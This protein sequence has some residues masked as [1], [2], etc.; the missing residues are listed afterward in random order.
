MG[1]RTRRRY[2]SQKKLLALIMLG[3]LFCGV[4]GIYFIIKDDLHPR[5]SRA[6]SRVDLPGDTIDEQSIWMTKIESQNRLLENKLSFLEETVKS[7]KKKEGQQEKENTLLKMELKNLK[8][9]LSD[10]ATN[11]LAYQTAKEPPRSTNTLSFDDLD[12]ED[13]FTPSEPLMSLVEYTYEGDLEKE[14]TTFHVDEMIP[15]GTTVKALIVSSV[16]APCGALSSSDPQPI[17]LRLLD[18]ARLP[19]SVRVRLKGGMLIGGAYGDI[20]SER[21]YIRLERLT[22]VKRDGNFIE[23]DVAGFVSGEDGKYGVRGV[24]VDKSAALI[25]NAAFSGFFG[26]MA[27]YFQSTL[28]AQNISPDEQPPFYYLP[29][30]I[31]YDLLQNSS[32]QGASNAL[33]KISEY[34]IKRAEQLMPVIQVASG[35]CVDITFTHGAKLGDLYT[36]EKVERVREE[37]RRVSDGN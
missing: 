36:K 7:S 17:K 5:R 10:V 3:T 33:D 29:P 16:D 27:Q 35:R 26:G 34:Y 1:E 13:P 22:Q 31:K 2:R 11:N 14:K 8:E 19:K 15:S 30:G 25:K 12:L 32:L 9:E 24:V 18:D 4:L 23:T 21:V 20:S 6:F 37:S 28:N